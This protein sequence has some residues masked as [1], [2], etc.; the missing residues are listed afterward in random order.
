MLLVRIAVDW[1]V[2]LFM[3]DY[4]NLE[5]LVHNQSYVD[6]IEIEFERRNKRIELFI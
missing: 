1:L 3:S 5:I 6:D 4:Q 2:E